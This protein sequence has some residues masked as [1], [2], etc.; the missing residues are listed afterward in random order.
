MYEENINQ[1][2]FSLLKVDTCK[3]TTPKYFLCETLY[4]RRES[5]SFAVSKQTDSLCSVT[6][7]QIKQIILI[8]I[9][10]AYICTNISSFPLPT[11]LPFLYLTIKALLKVNQS[12]KLELAYVKNLLIKIYM[13]T[14]IPWNKPTLIFRKYIFIGKITATLF[15]A[16][17]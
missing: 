17:I 6:I 16:L 5:I 15:Q 11:L 13:L 9:F 2:S 14:I 7:C 12:Y 3:F 8:N 1:V 10:E 4:G